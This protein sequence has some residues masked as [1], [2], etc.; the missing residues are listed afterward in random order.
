MCT[1]IRRESKVISFAEWNYLVR[2][3]TRTAASPNP[4]PTL[5]SPA[6]WDFLS[7]AE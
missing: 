2:G 5:L 6:G 3:T 4:D 1:A 7:Y